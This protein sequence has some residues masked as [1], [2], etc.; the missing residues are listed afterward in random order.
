[1]AEKA[2]KQ[3]K[4]RNE[5]RRFKVDYT[6]IDELAKMTFVMRVEREP[7]IKVYV[8]TERSPG[9]PVC[10]RFG[11]VIVQQQYKECPWV[12]PLV[13]AG[14]FAKVFNETDRREG[15]SDDTH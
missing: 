1:M 12:W 8:W 10:A 9:Y 4:A 13:E 15:V 14:G 5:M 2:E 11:E 3:V 7:E 6:T